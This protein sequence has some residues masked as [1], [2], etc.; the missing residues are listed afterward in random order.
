ME[1]Q[2]ITL[3]QLNKSIKA[4]LNEYFTDSYWIIAE[5]AQVKENFSGHCYLELIEKE[6]NG[7]KIIAQAKATIW[8]Y[9]YRILKPYFETS[10]GRKLTEGLK[11]LINVKVEF[12][13]LYGLSLNI[14]DIEPSYTVGDLALKKKEVID[15]LIAEGV[16]E[17]NKQLA[18]PLV[19]QRIAVISSD[20]AAGYEDFTK[21]LVNNQYGYKFFIKLFPAFMQGDKAEQSIIESLDLVY[22]DIKK[23]DVVT[24]IRGGGSQSDLS[25]FDSY[26]LANHV[27]QFPLPVITGIGHEKDESVVDMVANTRLKTPTATAA[28]I[29][30]KIVDFEAHINEME[31]Q[32]VTIAQ[33]IIDTEQNRLEKTYITL[34]LPLQNIFL[35]QK[36]I[37][38]N[39]TLKAK[40]T[41]EHQLFIFRQTLRSYPS[42]ITST[43]AGY[44]NNYYR[45]FTVYAITLKKAINGNTKMEKARLELFTKTSEFSN[46]STLLKKGYS[47]TFHNQKLLTDIGQVNETDTI[48][49]RLYN[50]IIDSKV[51]RKISKK[52]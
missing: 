24:I 10:T 23:F 27:A 17:M 21:H 4:S 31:H 52:H 40:Q 28:F 43:I 41:I 30:D 50:G 11:V 35:K 14:I 33:A 37:F 9:T 6:Q 32:V 16:F 36:Q 49:T 7:E 19:P 12:H 48:E 51:V 46:P 3:Y 47:L 22:N 25:C 5:I 29:I 13:E 15:K 18:F 42:I 20:T 39:N 44:I 8:S 38:Q 45:E 34:S 1:K 2:S 26:W